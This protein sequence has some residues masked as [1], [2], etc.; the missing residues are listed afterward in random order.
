MKQSIKLDKINLS[1]TSFVQTVGHSLWKKI[2]IEA[3]NHSYIHMHTIEIFQLNKREI[4][5]LFHP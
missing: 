5:K 1:E 4:K 3:I 2:Y